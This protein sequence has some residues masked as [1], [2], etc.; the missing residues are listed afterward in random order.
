MLSLQLKESPHSVRGQSVE[1][2]H[3][4]LASR[5]SIMPACTQLF[6]G[7]KSSPS[8]CHAVWADCLLM[9]WCKC[10]YGFGEVLLKPSEMFSLQSYF[11]SCSLRSRVHILMFAVYKFL[12]FS[13]KTFL[14]RKLMHTKSN[15]R[16]SCVHRM[17]EESWPH[18]SICFCW[19]WMSCKLRSKSA[20][21]KRKQKR[22][23]C[24]KCSE[25]DQPPSVQTLN[26]I[27]AKS[28]EEE[29]FS[30]LWKD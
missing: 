1:D 11:L 19:I 13:W 26:L 14:P 4:Y 15:P 30:Q 3:S 18:T 17:C 7:N 28:D 20:T 5:A 6:A 16:V 25:V 21:P 9:K 22:W 2:S 10:C 24:S 8:S 29:K 12:R 23:E 27:L